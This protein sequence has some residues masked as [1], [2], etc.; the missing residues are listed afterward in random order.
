MAGADASAFKAQV[1]AALPKESALVLTTVGGTTGGT[2]GTPI[3]QP[4]KD[5]IG[6]LRLPF[7]ISDDFSFDIGGSI[8]MGGITE[9]SNVIGTYTGTN[10]ALVLAN[11]GTQ[12]G[13]EFPNHK[14]RV[15]AKKRSV[16]RSDCQ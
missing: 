11:T 5:L 8:S 13:P 12:A 7:L 3:G 1:N 4:A 2:T 9:H 16:M 6:H 10:G 14:P 15:K